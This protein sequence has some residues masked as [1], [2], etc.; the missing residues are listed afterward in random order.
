[1]SLPNYP[2]SL[3]KGGKHHLNPSRTLAGDEREVTIRADLT[4]AMDIVERI[5]DA[6]YDIKEVSTLRVE[7]GH[8]G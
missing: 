5:R 7:A 4:Q 3:R 1:M 8:E 6:G 2:R